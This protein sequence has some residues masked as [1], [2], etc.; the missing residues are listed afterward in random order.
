[1]KQATRPGKPPRIAWGINLTAISLAV[2]LW[3]ID[4]LF[5]YLWLAQGQEDFWDILL[6]FRDPHEM[7]MRLSYFVT[8]LFSGVVVGMFL[9]RQQELQYRAEETAENLRITLNSIGDGVIATDTQGCVTRMN[10]VAQELTGWSIEQARGEPF[11]TVF[12][13]VHA[14]TRLPAFDPVEYVLTSKQA[15]GLANH[16]VLI[17]Q[18]G[19]EYQ[20]ADS[21]A[22]IQDR[23]GE[24]SGVVLV[25][26]DVTEQYRLRDEMEQANA[27]LTAV[28][29]QS[30]IPML[31]AT[32]EDGC[33][34]LINQACLDFLGG[35]KEQYLLKNLHAIKQCWKCMTP[36]GKELQ[37]DE[38]PIFATLKGERIQGMELLVE[39]LAGRIRHVLVEGIPICSS[40]GELLAGLV[41]FPDITERRKIDEERTKLQRLES[42]GTLAGG[43]AHDFNNILM[44]VFGGMELAKMTL[45]P[46]HPSYKY[47]ET[48][49][50]AL[51]RATHLTKQLLTFAKGGE[52]LLETFSLKQLVLDAVELNLS[53]SNVKAEV[54]LAGNLWPI[55][56]DRG[57][58]SHVLANLIINAKQAM[59]EGGYL[60]I[61]AENFPSLLSENLPRKGDF[62]QIILRDE[63]VG[64]PEEHKDR[65][66][67]P[68][69]TTKENGNGL[70]LAI[71][72]SVVIR[73]KGRVNFE[74]TPEKGTTFTLLLPADKGGQC[75]E[76]PVPPQ[77]WVEALDKG[78]VLVMDD[79]RIVREVAGDMLAMLGYEVLGVENGELALE[80]YKQAQEQK[81]PFA[82]V[83]MDLTIPGHMGGEEAVSQ[84]LKM[85]PEAKV[86]V[87][88][89][90]STDPIM[91]AYGEY[92]FKGRLVK[93]FQLHNLQRELERVLS[94]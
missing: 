60:F 2:M 43:I 15:I 42:V 1:M 11:S 93:P 76:E 50:Q 39:D 41:M 36:D 82:C 61:T 16:T 56:A 86:I 57:Q 80:A 27:L 28:V 90:Y 70:G 73:H 47:I 30:H 65:I 25:F 18:S 4:T 35:V 22:P 58:I 81:S 21:A 19:E 49:H 10:P 77:Q 79:E 31:M 13:I 37:Q 84:L 32:S 26:R 54:D 88:S 51:D 78:R 55:R 40:S 66:F 89:G 46:E 20:I 83:I 23:A 45:A 68:Y 3:C 67:E 14:Q 33:V 59:P 6:P 71:V 94:Q 63:G 74:S 5:E 92:G 91:A 9:Q 72:H 17:A 34:R 52:P 12:K 87:A 53:G 8:L 62:V 75:V 64:I 85:D 48:A 24:I 7:L 29:E 69:F 44:G 38:V